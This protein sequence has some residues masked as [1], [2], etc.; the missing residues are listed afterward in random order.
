MS[1]HRY[2][3]KYQIDKKAAEEALQD[4]LAASGQDD[5]VRRSHQAFHQTGS[6]RLG[7]WKFWTLAAV[8]AA[9]LT[10]AGIALWQH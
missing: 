6:K 8:L 9:A 7:H 5:I 2:N 10:F 3:R 1:F 4:I